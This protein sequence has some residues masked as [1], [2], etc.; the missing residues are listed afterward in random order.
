[1]FRRN[2]EESSP[3]GLARSAGPWAPRLL[4]GLPLARRDPLFVFV[5]VAL[6][7]TFTDQRP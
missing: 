6:L 3:E 7:F 2:G 4:A 5:F 1:M